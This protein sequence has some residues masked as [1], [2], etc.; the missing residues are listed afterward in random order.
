MRR[1]M[2][3]ISQ[4]FREWNLGNS[5]PVDSGKVYVNQDQ[6]TQ[7]PQVFTWLTPEILSRKP[8]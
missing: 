2:H 1:F 5:D 3:K 4:E 8:H 6:L 7:I